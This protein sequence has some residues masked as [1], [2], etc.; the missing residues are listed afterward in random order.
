VRHGS[1]R[2]SLAVASE[3]W[4]D[5][6]RA[7]VLRRHPEAG[8]AGR[9]RGTRELVASGNLFIFPYRFRRDAI[10]VLAVIHGSANGNVLIGV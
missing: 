8:R 7:A 4:E 10:Q 2:P 9:I 3:S 6:T 1:L 5:A